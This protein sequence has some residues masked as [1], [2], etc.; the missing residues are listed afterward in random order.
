MLVFSVTIYCY[1]KLCCIAVVGLIY[2]TVQLNRGGRK[3]C[4]H[5]KSRVVKIM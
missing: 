2:E 1:L 4:F 5:I 3:K